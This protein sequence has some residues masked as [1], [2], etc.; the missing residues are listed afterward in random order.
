MSNNAVLRGPSRNPLRIHEP[1]G[2]HIPR[3]VASSK[4]RHIGTAHT[5]HTVSFIP[6]CQRFDKGMDVTA[7]IVGGTGGQMEWKW[8]LTLCLPH[9][10]L[11]ASSKY[12][13]L[14]TF[15]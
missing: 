13:I 11:I 15:S 8:G 5:L 6:Q 9:V 14:F 3:A 10:I 7:Q 2:L 4:C 1:N 12:A